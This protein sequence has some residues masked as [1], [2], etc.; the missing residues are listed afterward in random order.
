MNTFPTLRTA[1]LLISAILLPFALQAQYTFTTNN[2]GSLNISAFSGS[3]AVT[4]PDTFDNLPITSIGSDAFHL[5]ALSSVTM[6]TNM[7]SIGN[8]AFESSSGLRNVTIGP[9]VTSIGNGAFLN[10]AELKSIVVPDSVTNFGNNIFTSDPQLYS[11]TLGNGVPGLPDYTF[12]YCT[13]LTN[14]VI[15]SGVASFGNAV[16]TQCPL[17]AITVD[18]QNQFYC[19]ADGVFFDKQKTKLIVYPVG[20]GGSTYTIPESVTV[21]GGDAFYNCSSF[22]SITIP[23]AVTDIQ[24]SAFSGCSG[25]TNVTL[26]NNVLTLDTAAFESCSSLTS[27]TLPDSVTTIGEYAFY[28]CTSL[29]NVVIGRG[30]TLIVGGAFPTCPALQGVYFRGNAPSSSESFSGDGSAT[31]YYLPGTVGWSSRFGDPY[32]LPTAPWFLPNPTILN[33]GT[34]FGVQSNGFSFMVSW[35]TNVSVE[36]E[37][38][39]NLA[40]QS[41]TSVVT[42]TLSGGSF[43]FTDSGWTNYPG[44]FYRL[45]SP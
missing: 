38:C 27:V 12:E 43:Y 36:V 23:N 29:T 7:T 34:N 40:N 4:I 25:L 31:A 26:G 32:G 44:R 5:S 13:S 22:T 37:A 18:P 2:D 28:N 35:A 11:V 20:K 39:T 33:F 14:V 41:W 1:C 42:N 17:L 19:S 30:V 45:R 6:G 9:N 16:F 8:G 15:G 21:I 10:C 24:F 3:G